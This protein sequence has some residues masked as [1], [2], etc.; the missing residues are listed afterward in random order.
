[1]LRVASSR[2]PAASHSTTPAPT[3]TTA[4]SRPHGLKAQQEYWPPPQRWSRTRVR[5]SWPG[6][7]SRKRRR[8]PSASYV[9]SRPSLVLREKGCRAPGRLSSNFPVPGCHSLTPSAHSD[10]VT[11]TSPAELAETIRPP[12]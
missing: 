6:S 11:R 5:N 9:Q 8:V 7:I 3:T 12:P 10:Q 2:P 1:M 4:S